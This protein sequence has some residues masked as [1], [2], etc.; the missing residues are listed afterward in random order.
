LEWKSFIVEIVKA[1]AWPMTVLLIFAAL[2][3][4]LL[5]LFPLLAR[6][7]FKDLEFN[8]SRKL[9]KTAM[10]AAALPAPETFPSDQAY[11]G[12]L[13]KLADSSPRAAILEAWIKLEKAA[14]EAARQK[15]IDITYI[16]LRNPLRLT[17][18]LEE[19]GIID[20]RQ[21]RV[22]TDLRDLRN[23]AAH[24]Q[25]FEPSKSDALEYIQLSE[26]LERSL[27]EG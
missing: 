22:F 23:S 6:L 3:K 26:R 19:K 17:Q 27:R 4:P 25:G 10:D 12:H 7:K 5:N 11:N 9:E 1:F 14:I 15:D 2:R 18:F 24:A 8:F 13:L 20:N 16:I 21:G